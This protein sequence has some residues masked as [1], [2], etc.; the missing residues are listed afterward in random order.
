MTATG[1][2]RRIDDLGRVVIPKEIRRHFKLN[3]GDPVEVFVATDG[4]LFKKYSLPT[5]I[6]DDLHAIAD[7]ISSEADNYYGNPKSTKLVELAI[8]IREIRKRFDKLID[9]SEEE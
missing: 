6:S 3:E 2:V 4:I 1:I 8:E 7:S 5:T 9:E